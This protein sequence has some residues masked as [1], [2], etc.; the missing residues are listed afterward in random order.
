MKAV[1]YLI[2]SIQ[3]DLM[4]PGIGVQKRQSLAPRNLVD[5][6]VDAGERNMIFRAGPVDMLEVNAHAK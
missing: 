4:I 6:L 1:F 3:S 5:D 2:E